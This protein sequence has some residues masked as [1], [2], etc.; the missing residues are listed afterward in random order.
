MQGRG[1]T[2]I[3]VNCAAV[4]FAGSKHVRIHEMKGLHNSVGTSLRPR[5]PP[6]SAGHQMP[7]ARRHF[8][9][10]SDMAT[11]EEI[12]RKHQASPWE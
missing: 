10:Y 9:A 3:A 2:E 11:R 7:A 4:P 12:Q 5:M 6:K 1:C 8:S